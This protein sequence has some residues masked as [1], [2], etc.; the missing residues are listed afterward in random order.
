MRDLTLFGCPVRLLMDID[1]ETADATDAITLADNGTVAISTD[2][3][4]DLIHQTQA[5]KFCPCCGKPR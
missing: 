1:G 5:A 4:I 2:R 3:I